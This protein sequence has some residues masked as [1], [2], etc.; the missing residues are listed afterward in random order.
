MD[1]HGSVELMARWRVGDQQA[2]E[3]LFQRHAERL[4]ALVRTRLSNQLA[5][6]FDPEDVVQSAY[7]SFFVG[8]RDGRYV[9]TQSGDLWHLMVRITLNKLFR[10]VQ[11]HQAGKRAFG[12]ENDVQGA[13]GLSVF[14]AE[15]LARDPS[16]VEAAALAEELEQLMRGL[17]VHRRR[18]FELR[19]QGHT[20][21]E[22]AADTRHS[23]RTVRRR[24]DQIKESL[25]RRYQEQFQ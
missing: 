23:V 18:I 19:L 22:I 17:D 3:A 1:D 20:L 24:L 11:H 25:E 12:R 14:E 8:A 21:E 13:G 5:R 7:R 4:L 15:S 10:Q 9:L 6:R 16:P 2:A